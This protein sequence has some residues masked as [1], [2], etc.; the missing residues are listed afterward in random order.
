M[1]KHKMGKKVCTLTGIAVLFLSL[2]GC[3]GTPAPS[4]VQKASEIAPKELT[5]DQREILDLIGSQQEILL[6]DYHTKEAYKKFEAWVEIYKDGELLE[7][8][9]A[10]LSLRVEEKRPMN[11]QFAV[12]VTQT[13]DFQWTLT[14]VQQ[15][16]SGSTRMSSTSDPNPVYGGTDARAFGPINSPAAI[17]DSK[18]IILY[19]SL[20]SDAGSIAFYDAEELTKR[21]ELLKNYTYAHI[22]KCR[23]SN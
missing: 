15:H 5:Q 12:I 16:D 14:T 10:S 13:P 8:H 6:F 23:F 22:I 3:A 17:R 7:P 4:P 21:P 1:D 19:T 9:A 18:E 20:F 2:C 11:G